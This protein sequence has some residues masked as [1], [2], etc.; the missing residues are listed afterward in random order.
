VDGV[1][2]GQPRGGDTGHQALGVGR[3]KGRVGRARDRQ[4]RRGDARQPFMDV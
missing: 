3:W 1:H 4:R 2:D